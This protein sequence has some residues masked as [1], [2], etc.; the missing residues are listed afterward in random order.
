MDLQREAFRVL[1]L[2]VIGCL[3]FLFALGSVSP[4]EVIEVTVVVLVLCGLSVLHGWDVRRHAGE[5]PQD[6]PAARSRRRHGV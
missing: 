6:A 3:A 2:G 1:T 5:D 4:G